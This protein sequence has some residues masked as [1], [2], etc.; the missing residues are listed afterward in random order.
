MPSPDTAV[1]LTKSGHTLRFDVD[2]GSELDLTDT[3]DD[4]KAERKDGVEN[5]ERGDARR[6]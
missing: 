6:G 4:A 3:E 2:E 5:A 1:T